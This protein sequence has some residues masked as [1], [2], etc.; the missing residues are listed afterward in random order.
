[1]H[2]TTNAVRRPESTT[3][4][5][6]NETIALHPFPRFIYSRASSIPAL[7]PFPPYKSEAESKGSNPPWPT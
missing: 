2:L 3:T 5:I 7:C 1:M 4:Q 6:E